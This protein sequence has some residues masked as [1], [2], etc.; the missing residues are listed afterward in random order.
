ME[1]QFIRDI[2]CKYVYIITPKNHGCDIREFVFN[3]VTVSI[4][5][6]IQKQPI[7]RR[8]PHI[9]T[10]IDD[11]LYPNFNGYTEIMGSDRFWKY[12]QPYP[13]IFKELFRAISHILQF[14]LF[15]SRRFN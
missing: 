2:N 13:G 12:K 14:E 8:I 7:R 10:D 3:V 15:F 1:A 11:T 9:L 5:D 6:S 4:L